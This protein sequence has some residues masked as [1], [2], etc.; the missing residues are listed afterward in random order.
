[1]PVQSL[2]DR[3]CFRHLVTLMPCLVHTEPAFYF[4]SYTRS[5]VSFIDAGRF[6]S[7]SRRL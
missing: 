7:G 3:G 6:A 4:C 1:M 5:A 2:L